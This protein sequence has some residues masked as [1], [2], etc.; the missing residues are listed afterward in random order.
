MSFESRAQA[1]QELYASIQDFAGPIT[2]I[3][4]S[5][6]GNVA[7]ELA[8]CAEKNPQQLIIERLILLACPIQSATVEFAQSPLFKKVFSLYALEDMLQILDPQGLY[9]E[10]KKRSKS[11]SV[12]DLFSKRT[13]PL[14]NNVVQAQILMHDQNPWHISFML[15]SF[16]KYLPAVLDLLAQESSG[17]MSTVNIPDHGK[18]YIVKSE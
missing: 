13:L 16:L 7:L 3:G 6:G 15:P 10:T 5:H 9:T 1:A 14:Y 11:A 2:I 17:T 4:H 8:L 18:P 12:Q